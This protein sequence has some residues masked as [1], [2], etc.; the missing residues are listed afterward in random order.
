MKKPKLLVKHLKNLK[1]MKFMKRL[2]IDQS[3]NDYFFHEKSQ[4]TLVR[5]LRWYGDPRNQ[6]VYWTC[7]ELGGG[8]A[9]IGYWLKKA[10]YR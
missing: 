10:K 2:M 5:V 9:G 1:G 3:F 4:I 7:P 8:N 6:Y